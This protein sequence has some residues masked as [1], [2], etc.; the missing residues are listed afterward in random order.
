MFVKIFFSFF[1]S[2]FGNKPAFNS[3]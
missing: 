2:F 3:H 1:A